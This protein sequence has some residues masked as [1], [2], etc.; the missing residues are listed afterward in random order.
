MCTLLLWLA[1]RPLQA[2]HTVGAGQ[3][4]G[5]RSAGGSAAGHQLVGQRRGVLR[6]PALPHVVQLALEGEVVDRLLDRAACGH[7]VLH[8]C[9]GVGGGGRGWLGAG[10]GLG[11]G[12]GGGWAGLSGLLGG[13]PQLQGLGWAG[14]GGQSAHRC[15]RAPALGALRRTASAS[16]PP[17]RP[18][19]CGRR[20]AS[21]R[22]CR[23]AAGR[24]PP[25]S[26]AGMVEE[27]GGSGGRAGAGWAVSWAVRRRR[28][29]EP[30]WGGA[31]EVRRAAVPVRSEPPVAPTLC[32]RPVMQLCG[33]RAP[34]GARAAGSS[35]PQPASAAGPRRS[36]PRGGRP[37]P[38]HPPPWPPGRLPQA[39]DLPKA[40]ASVR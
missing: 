29:A 4:W 22:W 36:W 25:P 15:A 26:C 12:W 38:G 9:R 10:W 33:V 20:P 35:H 7:L 31:A 32:S 16:A 40:C 5:L 34:A 24:T 23:P 39:P 13:V 21:S 18:S 2:A 27:G 19:A 3:R 17:R 14:L 1:G 6:A 30:A 11:G 28:A 8:A 37:W